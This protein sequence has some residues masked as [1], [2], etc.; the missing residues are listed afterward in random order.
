[1]D[2]GFLEGY[3]AAPAASA[4]SASAAGL[5]PFAAP[6]PRPPSGPGAPPLRVA[7]VTLCDGA[8]ADICE[9]SIDN[10]RAY[11]ARHGTRTQLP[12]TRCTHANR[13]S[14]L[15]RTPPA[16][17]HHHAGYTLIVANDAIDPSRPA[18]WSKIPAVS[19][20]FEAGHELVMCADADALVMNPELRVEELF[21]WS[22]HQTLAAD[23]NGL[24]SGALPCGI[25]LASCVS[26]VCARSDGVLARSTQQACG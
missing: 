20:A 12:H 1:V 8:L 5:A 24:N 14:S 7:L 26:R 4:A 9:A 6:L 17:R 15:T 2:I 21:N 16:P 22:T 25:L 13:L 11:A 3:P 19:R 18:A 10:K 23:H